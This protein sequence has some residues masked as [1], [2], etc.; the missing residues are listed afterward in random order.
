MVIG[1][2]PH[3]Y[4]IVIEGELRPR[5]ASAFDGVTVC[6][7]HGVTEITGP[8]IHTSHLRGPLERIAAT[9]TTAKGP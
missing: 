3:R 9:G 4:R 8:I 1:M 6:A 7:H 5:C 2:S